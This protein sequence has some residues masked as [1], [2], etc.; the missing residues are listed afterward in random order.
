MDNMDEKL[1]GNDLALILESLM[2]TRLKFEST[3]YPTYK[4]KQEKIERV[5]TVMSKVKALGN[6]LQ[7]RLE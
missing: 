5:N 2:Y 1:T 7:K 3:E 4:M 6:E